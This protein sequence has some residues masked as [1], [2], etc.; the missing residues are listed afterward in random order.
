MTQDAYSPITGSWGVEGMWVLI[1]GGLTVAMVGLLVMCLTTARWHRL[2]GTAALL[3][4]IPA[5]VVAMRLGDVRVLGTGGKSIGCH[6]RGPVDYQTECGSA[7]LDRYLL[8]AVPLLL[9]AVALGGLLI[10]LLRSRQA[11]AGVR[12]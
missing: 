4:A 10:Y 8:G 11:L 3:M 5:Y 2:V 12:R 1:V 7:Y 9:E 6:L